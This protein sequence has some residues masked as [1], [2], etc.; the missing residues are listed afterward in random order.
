MAKV[1]LS[2]WVNATVP[3]TQTSKIFEES[4]SPALNDTQRQKIGTICAKAMQQMQ[5]AGAA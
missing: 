3:A 5:Y 1:K 2:I 4:P